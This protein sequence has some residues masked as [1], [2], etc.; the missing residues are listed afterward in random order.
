MWSLSKILLV[1]ISVTT[2]IKYDP[3]PPSQA[4]TE[5][6]SVWA[7]KTN[8]IA[9][10]EATRIICT[11]GWSDFHEDAMRSII[12][13]QMVTGAGD[14]NRFLRVL[15]GNDISYPDLGKRFSL[16]HTHSFKRMDAVL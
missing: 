3:S 2:A 16:F 7:A 13:K 14:R 8:E 5:F 4:L 11:W 15:E 1:G 6:L 10:G 9:P 12:I